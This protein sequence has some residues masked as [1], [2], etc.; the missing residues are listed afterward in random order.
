MKKTTNRPRKNWGPMQRE[1]LKHIKGNDLRVFM[2]LLTYADKEA[3]C[4]P[5]V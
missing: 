1:M 4:F 5:A 3:K 2:D